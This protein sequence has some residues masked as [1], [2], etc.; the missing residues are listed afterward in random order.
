[1]NSGLGTVRSE[2]VKLAGL[3][4]LPRNYQGVFTC[5]WNSM[6]L[7]ESCQIKLP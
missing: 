5:G 6:L 4:L 1:M 2:R 3:V 7:F